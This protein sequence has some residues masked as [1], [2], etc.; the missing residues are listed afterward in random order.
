MNR[1]EPN[2]LPKPG[3]SRPP[4]VALLS[5][6]WPLY[7]RPSIQLGS[8]KAFLL[9]HIP[10]IQAHAHH[11]YLHV[12]REIGYDPYRQI[13]ERSWL[14][15]CP[16]AAL[17]HP[18]R[19]KEVLRFWLARTRSN[20]LRDPRDFQ[21]LCQAIETASLSFLESQDWGAC[22]LAGFSVC[23]AQLT[24][25]LYFVRQLKHR[26]PDLPIVLGGS[27]CAGLLGE[28]LLLTVPEV[29]YVISGEGERPLLSLVNT[30]MQGERN[31]EDL[32]IPGLFHRGGPSPAQVQDQVPSLNHLPIPDYS[33]Y[34]RMAG[35]S[36]QGFSF[37][38][39]LPVE[40]SR[41]CWWNKGGPPKSSA[42]CAFCNLN[43]QW[44][45]YRAKDNKR[46]LQEIRTLVARHQILSL[47]FMDNLLPPGGLDH[48]FQEMEE[49]RLD[50]DLFC[51]IR[52]RTRCHTLLA[53]AR[54]GVEEVQVGVESLSTGLLELI[55]KGTTAMDNLEIMRDCEDPNLP[56]LVGNLI[57]QFPGSNE[58]H[59]S[60]TLRTLDFVLPF[61]PLKA[62]PFWL[63]YGSPVWHAPQKYGIR[64][65]GNHPW[66]RYLFPAEDLCGRQLMIQS[67]QGGIRA[68]KHLWRPVQEKVKK[69]EDTYHRLH[70]EPGSGPILSYRDGHD[71]LII[72]ER[73]LHQ[74]H[75]SHRLR[76]RS[77]EMYLFCRTQRTLQ[78]ILSR[79]PS[80]GSDQVQA[81]LASL[82][83]KRLL[84]QESDRYLSLAVPAGRGQ[85][86]CSP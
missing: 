28:S 54:A 9:Q 43:L 51:E 12:A 82:V 84:F 24:S 11:V 8:L 33:D 60:E 72:R 69:W 61:R 73:R 49:T 52:A 44:R 85:G 4:V 50:V 41:G 29:D 48:L 5:T 68:Q 77:R 22:L 34:F 30:L 81:F 57:L 38:P 64:I 67:Y 21:E 63:G 13:S 40:M 71:F 31:P 16:Y 76:G 27:A 80:F 65:T 20:P 17:L 23:L 46:M 1:P 47:S 2:T 14:A 39:V 15:E 32:S 55:R 75:S 53:M 62:I 6:P 35:S 56:N 10:G 86:G 18:E 37:L 26:C 42:G 66:Y 3:G 78:E 83:D 79:F 45:G 70:R 7:H 58:T 25:T 36:G 59:V 19:Q 74:D